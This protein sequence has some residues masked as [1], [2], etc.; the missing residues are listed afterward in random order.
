MFSNPYMELVITI[1][2][3]STRQR[4]QQTAEEAVRD[5][6]VRETSVALWKEAVQKKVK[7]GRSKYLQYKCSYAGDSAKE[8]GN[9]TNEKR[10]CIEG[11]K[12]MKEGTSAQGETERWKTGPNGSVTHFL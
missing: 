8:L 12:V 11:I 10:V 5:Y 6:G 7:G 9:K 2:G 3:G 4:R 1:C